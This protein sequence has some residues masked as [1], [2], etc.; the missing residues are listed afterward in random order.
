MGTTTNSFFCEYRV[1]QLFCHNVEGAHDINQVWSK[2]AGTE[3]LQIS[4][5]WL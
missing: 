2:L 4:K 3:I 1:L 5:T